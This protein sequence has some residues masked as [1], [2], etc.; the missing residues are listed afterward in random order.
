MDTVYVEIE[1]SKVDDTST[2]METNGKIIVIY[3]QDGV[4]RYFDEC[5]IGTQAIS[6]LI[7]ENDVPFSSKSYKVLFEDAF[8]VEDVTLAAKFHHNDLLDEQ[9]KFLKE[10]E[11]RNFRKMMRKR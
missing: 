10:K 11:K 6:C 7:C 5:Q 9:E 3:T 8:P 2:Q 1:K 4:A